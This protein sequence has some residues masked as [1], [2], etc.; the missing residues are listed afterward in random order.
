MI[1]GHHGVFEMEDDTSRDG[2]SGSWGTYLDAV[3][4]DCRLNL[5]RIG[6]LAG[7]RT[8]TLP[9]EA[10]STEAP[11]ASRGGAGA[12]KMPQRRTGRMARRA[13]N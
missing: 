9:K 4:E 7:R 5:R 6:T 8:E 1:C 10:G 11:P 3:L 2:A 13:C 12:G